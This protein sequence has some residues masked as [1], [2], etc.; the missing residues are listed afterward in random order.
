MG[1]CMTNTWWPAEQLQPMTWTPQ[2]LCQRV[3]TLQMALLPEQPCVPG[4]KQNEK[5]KISHGKS[6]RKVLVVPCQLFCVTTESLA[7]Q[8]ASKCLKQSSPNRN[9][10]RRAVRPCSGHLLVYRGRSMMYQ[11]E[12]LCHH[13][14]LQPSSRAGF[15]W[16]ASH[17]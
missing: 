13:A 7:T 9:H 1:W 16:G 3:F 11:H 5:K 14:N 6:P 17:E 15:C 4:A 8:C 12:M 2:G 10:S